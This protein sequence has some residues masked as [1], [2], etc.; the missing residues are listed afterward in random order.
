MFV[1]NILLAMSILQIS[2]VKHL[3]FLDKKWELQGW[4]TVSRLCGETSWYQGRIIQGVTGMR[5]NHRLSSTLVLPSGCYPVVKSSRETGSPF[6][7]SKSNTVF[8]FMIWP[9]CLFCTI[10][11]RPLCTCGHWEE[12]C[13]CCTSLYDWGMLL[14]LHGGAPALPV[15][16]G[17][18][19]LSSV[20]PIT[21]RKS[22]GLWPVTPACQLPS[23]CLC[24]RS[25]TYQQIW[26][27]D[28]HL[29]SEVCIFFI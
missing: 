28:G 6:L 4:K 8:V 5:W 14:N 18:A 27:V 23:C 17:S 9:E 26:Q 25:R 19:G 13:P 1:C 24:C 16:W 20:P 21:V 10:N 15:T 3:C 11:P 22:L 2:Q 7:L 29:V 12:I